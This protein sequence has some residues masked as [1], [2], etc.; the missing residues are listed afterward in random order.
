VPNL[1]ATIGRY[2][3]TG[4]LGRGGMGVV[5]RAVDPQLDRPVAVKRISLDSGEPTAQELENRFLREARLAARLHHSAVATVFD[6]GRDGDALYLVMELVEGESLQRRLARGNFPS[7]GQS[8]ELAA[9]VAD[10]LAA[11]HQKGIIHRDVKP[12]NILLTVDGAVKVS[13]FGVAKAVGDATDLTRSGTVLG[14]PAYMA[15]EQIQGQGVDTRA[16][17]FSL[18][19]VLYEMLLHRRPFPA[20]TVTTLIYQILHQDPLDDPLAMRALGAELGIFLRQA[21]AKNPADRVPDA[22]TF[23][24][25]ARE[26]AVRMAAGEQVATGATLKLPGREAVAPVVP[27]VPVVPAEVPPPVPARRNPLWFAAVAG[28]AG[29]LVLA[30]AYWLLRRPP[31]PEVGVATPARV[32]AR[33]PAVP[34]A[35]STP[36]APPPTA[37][38][39]RPAPA[40]EASPADLE[41]VVTAPP[42]GE[43]RTNPAARAARPGASPTAVSTPPAATPS[44]A[45]PPSRPAAP[46]AAAPPVSAPAA[47]EPEPAAPP[48]AAPQPVAPALPVAH[49]FHARKGAEFNV[50]PEEAI[51]AVN[52]H[53]IGTADEWDG[54]GGGKVYQFS[55]P[56]TYE[57]LLSL[58]GYES[59]RVQVVVSADAKREIADV[60]SELQER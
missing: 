53:R 50:S 52:G 14:S 37:P 22:T 2:R 3:I 23:A 55:A 45:A 6:A 40:A 39:L 35:A 9:Q 48:P 32:E 47:V 58:D 28:V 8:L 60:D 51:V 18:G 43:V 42:V 13:D 44:P 30:G 20:D 19:V 7:A 15:P 49:V 27:V 46:P 26:L 10:A 4:E 29:A 1:P 36:A 5:Y 16:D 33:A 21:L 11:A 38:E 25:R 59:M 54:S 31:A 12:A 57:I 17:I 24:R 41:T 56:G 34:E